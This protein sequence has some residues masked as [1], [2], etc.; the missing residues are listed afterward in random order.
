MDGCRFT[1]LLLGRLLRIELTVTGARCRKRETVPFPFPPTVA[2]H[3]TFETEPAA[4]G[5][6]VDT[7]SPFA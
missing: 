7:G 6:W 4:G 3:S 2:V 5:A 1:L